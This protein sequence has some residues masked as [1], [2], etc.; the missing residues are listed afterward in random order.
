LR[1]IAGTPRQQVVAENN[2]W[3]TASA[4]ALPAAVQRQRRIVARS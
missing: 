1:R 2:V 3:V 4:A